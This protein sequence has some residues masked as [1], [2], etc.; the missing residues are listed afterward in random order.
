M[1]VGHGWK[2]FLQTSKIANLEF[3]LPGILIKNEPFC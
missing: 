3:L 1:G 2:L